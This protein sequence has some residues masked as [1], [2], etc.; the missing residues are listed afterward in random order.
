LLFA[1]PFVIAILL[2]L[3]CASGGVVSFI[4]SWYFCTNSR[5]ED[6]RQGFLCQERWRLPS[7]YR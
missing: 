1:L 4:A 2:S 3:P 5:R 7:E 6:Q